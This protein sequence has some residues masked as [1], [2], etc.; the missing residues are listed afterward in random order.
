MLNET[1]SDTFERACYDLPG[2]PL[3]KSYF[4]HDVRITCYTS[5]AWA[6]AILDEMLG[7]FPEPAQLQGEITYSIVCYE[8]D[9]LFP[10]QLPGSRVRTDTMRLLTNTIL[11]Y[12]RDPDDMIEYQKYMALPPV[13]GT[14]LTVISRSQ[15]ILLTQLEMPEKYQA[16]FLRRYVFLL[17][18]GQ[19]MGRYG[20]EPCH[21]A[22]ITT[23]WDNQQGALLIG[24]SGSGKTTLALGCAS[25]GWGLLGDDLVMLRQHT[26]GDSTSAYTITHE[27]SVRPDSLELWHTLAFLR[28]YP[29]DPRDKR[30]C[31]VEQVRPGAARMHAPI[32]LLLFPSLSTETTSRATRLSKA[33]TLQALVDQCLGKIH[34]RPQS[35]EKLFLMLSQLAEQAPGYQL[36]IA[37][38]AH[39]GPQ[40]I[41]SLLAGDAYG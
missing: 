28:D 7:L 33:Y 5:H 1:I 11:K 12:Y 17:A 38:S 39:D 19:A 24:A 8:S 23:P 35:Q 37:R 31:S 13:N 32:R 16:S 2:Q 14:T 10:V 21:A 15:N 41:S 3:S 4:F 30:Y 27:V 22:A 6:L 26:A 36:A 25:I 9:S 40:I 29:A 18:L 34:A 20:F